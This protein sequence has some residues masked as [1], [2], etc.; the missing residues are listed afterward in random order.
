MNKKISSKLMKNILDFNY[1]KQVQYKTT[2]IIISFTY[3]VGVV[4]AFITKQLDFS[5]RN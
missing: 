4:I 2:A 1:T 5:Y 3:I